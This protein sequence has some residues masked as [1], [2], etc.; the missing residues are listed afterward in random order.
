[1]G[2]VKKMKACS[3]IFNHMYGTCDHLDEATYLYLHI[4]LHVQ[5]SLAVDSHVVHFNYAYIVL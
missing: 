4:M 1:M 3:H 2:T 5:C